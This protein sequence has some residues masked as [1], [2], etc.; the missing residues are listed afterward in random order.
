MELEDHK[1][2]EDPLDSSISENSSGLSF[3]LFGIALSKCE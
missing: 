2:N 3:H 1:R